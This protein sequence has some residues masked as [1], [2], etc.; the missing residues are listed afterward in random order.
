[1]SERKMALV[2]GTNPVMTPNIHPPFYIGNAPLGSAPLTPN[3]GMVSTGGKR[4]Y[5]PLEA[6]KLIPAERKF[7]RVHPAWES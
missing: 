4:V 2:S 5:T 1:M 7:P 6:K 3:P